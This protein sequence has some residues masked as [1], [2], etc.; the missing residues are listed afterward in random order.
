MYE[1]LEAIKEGLLFVKENWL[2]PQTPKWSGDVHELVSACLFTVTARDI[3]MVIQAI[4]AGEPLEGFDG[5]NGII[6]N[7]KLIKV[8]VSN[9]GQYE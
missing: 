8:S 1:T 7:G 2:G 4:N 6:K 5:L 3:T 9:G